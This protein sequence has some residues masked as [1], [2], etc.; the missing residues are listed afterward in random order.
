MNNKLQDLLYRSF[1]TALSPEEQAQL[2]QALASDR[3]LQEEKRLLEEMRLM[4]SKNAE[5]KFKPFF[6]AKVM[7]KIRAQPLKGDD[8]I[9]S[10]VWSFRLT[11]IAATAVVLILFA[12]NSII[13]KDISID[14]LLSMPQTSIEETWELELPGEN[15]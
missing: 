5:L 6:S 4:I 9:S 1:D 10:L 12:H 7:Q 3:E 8:F 13:R 15:L 14:A 11:A 2:D